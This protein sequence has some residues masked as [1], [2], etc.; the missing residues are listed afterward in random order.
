MLFT[1]N[2]FKKTEE[3][4]EMFDFIVYLKDDGTFQ[5]TDNI[6]GLF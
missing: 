1:E 4:S 2:N 5:I 3:L 6:G